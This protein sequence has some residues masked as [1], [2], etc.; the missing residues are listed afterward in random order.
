[1]IG[2][3]E[4][5]AETFIRALRDLRAAGCDLLTIGQYLQ[6]T[7]AHASVARYY[8]ARGIRRSKTEAAAAGFADVEAG[9]LVRSSFHAHELHASFEQGRK[10]LMRYLIFSDVHGNLEALN[11]LLKFAQ[12]RRIDHYVCLGDLVGYGASPNETIQKIRTLKPLSLIRGNHDK[13]VIRPDS[14]ET[15][16]PIAAAAIH[17]TRKI[18]F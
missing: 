11:A 6:P 7:K 4:T 17:W 1:M 5:E 3:G 12:K 2:L 13:A 14:I 16:N 8:H 18:R 9:P 15:F 10:D